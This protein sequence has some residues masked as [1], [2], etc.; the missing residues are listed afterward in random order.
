MMSAT[1]NAA[2]F[3]QKQKFEIPPKIKILLF[4]NPKSSCVSKITQKLPPC[5]PKK[6]YG[7]FIKK[8]STSIVRCGLILVWKY[9]GK[10]SNFFTT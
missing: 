3:A 5:V 7:K 10:I 1:T 4:L 9:V 8:I 6:G 2:K